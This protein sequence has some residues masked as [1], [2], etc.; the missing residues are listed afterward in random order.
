MK[1]MLSIVLFTLVCAPALA[2]QMPRFL[3]IAKNADGSVKYLDQAAG[4]QYCS[5]HRAH[6]PSARELAKLSMSYGAKGIVDACA[7]DDD[8]YSV[9]AINAD[10]R[11]DSFNFSI[12]GYQPPAGDLGSNW[13]MSSSVGDE[14][15]GY[16]FF[17]LRGETGYV[18]SVDRAYSGAV[19]CVSGR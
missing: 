14:P 9:T 6:L 2:D 10:G 4:R 16:G 15:Y 11:F 12:A 8:C 19:R 5:T 18:F 17:G 3:E 1:K 13:F 7:S